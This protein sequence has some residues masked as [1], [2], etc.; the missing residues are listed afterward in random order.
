MDITDLRKQR[1]LVIARDHRAKIKT[2]VDT[3]FLVPSMSGSGGYLVDIEKGS[4][5]CPDFSSWGANGNPNGHVCKHLHAVIVLTSE[6]AMPDGSTVMATK[7]ITIARDHRAQTAA[8]R[9]EKVRVQKLLGTLVQCI[10]P[11]PYKGNGRPALPIGA[12]IY[13]AAMK[14]YTNQS[15]RLA[16]PDIEWCRELGL[17]ERVPSFN[18]IY[19]Y[20]E[21]PTVTPILQ[22]LVAEAAAPLALLET[23]CVYAADSTGFTTT[24]Y[25]GWQEDK[26]G[27][28]LKRRKE[29]RKSHVIAGTHTQGVMFCEPTLGSVGD[30]PLLR[31]VLLPGL[32]KR[33]PIKKVL[34][35]AG[36]LAKENAEAIAL[37]GA[38]PFIDFRDNCIG[39]DGPEAWNRMWHH[40]YAD[41]NDYKRHYNER[42]GVERVFQMVKE[43]WGDRLY[44]R[45]LTAQFNEILLKFLCHNLAQ[46][47]YAIEKFGIEPK[48]DRIFTVSE[49]A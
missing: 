17:V 2:I 16:T 1:G 11:I 36:Y 37:V 48:F 31:N 35:D 25:R 6:V 27:S 49:A 19:R 20:M 43:R 7:K 9:K 42:V 14:V 46:I 41:V 33:H 38:V 34:A 5:S 44:A 29:Y 24:A 18:S 30:S 8:K 15:G 3:M 13:G 26:P 10:E 4:C 23:N 12:V 47:N 32:A 22:L 39:S 28:K 21:S 45:T 40:F